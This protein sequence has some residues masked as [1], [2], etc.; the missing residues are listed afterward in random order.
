[1]LTSIRP[2]RNQEDLGSEPKNLR[3]RKKSIQDFQKDILFQ[4]QY[5]CVI[6]KPYD[7]RMCGDFDLT[8]EKLVADWIHCDVKALKWVHQLDFAT[9]GV[10]CIGLDKAA[11]ACASSA[12]AHRLPEKS[13]L[14]VLQG[15]LRY[16]DWPEFQQPFRKIDFVDHSHRSRNKRKQKAARLLKAQQEGKSAHTS[17]QQSWQTDLMKHN[18]QLCLD[19]L[20]RIRRDTPEKLEEALARNGEF[21]KVTT[22]YLDRLMESAKL[23]KL[24]RRLVTEIAGELP[25]LDSTYESYLQVFGQKAVDQ[26]AA[27]IRRGES[28]DLLAA[29]GAEQDGDDESLDGDDD[30]AE[31]EGER[32]DQRGEGDVAALSLSDELLHQRALFYREGRRAADGPP[33][34]YR[35]RDPADS[36]RPERLLIDVP[37]TEHE[38]DFRVEPC[39]PDHLQD[40]ERAKQSATELII[41][42]NRLT[43]QGQPA[44]KVLLRPLTGRRHQLRLHSLCL[45]HPIVGDFTYNS[46][47]RR[48]IAADPAGGQVSERM[49]LHALSLRIPYA[50][51]L[52]KTYAAF[53]EQMAAEG[54]PVWLVDVTSPDPFPVELGQLRPVLH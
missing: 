4:N 37:L 44:T 9:S 19:A 14:A 53:K 40:P 51:Q 27:K 42:D 29:G 49:M 21:K 31:G 47:F 35:Y 13:Y 43:Y 28:A 33:F 54:P 32:E 6:N 5:F 41:L 25:L 30:G 20:E 39:H 45:G 34:I 23:R 38:D 8:V 15:T 1:M 22:A 16:E 17:Y 18:L 50:P 11:T 12:F 24:L 2:N 3:S 48:Q 52:V 26:Q 36:E 7:V 10:L 46:F